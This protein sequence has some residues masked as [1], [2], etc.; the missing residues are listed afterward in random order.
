[1]HLIYDPEGKYGPP[2]WRIPPSVLKSFLLWIAM[3]AKRKSRAE[4][5][6]RLAQERGRIRVL[7]DWQRWG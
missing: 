7:R 1:V 2:L 5:R 4:R 6:I 3:I